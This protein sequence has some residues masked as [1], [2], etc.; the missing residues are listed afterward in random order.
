MM[1]VSNM[2]SAT[3]LPVDFHSAE[4][5]MSTSEGEAVAKASRQ[6]E[7]MLVR[8]ILNTAR[9]GAS[10]IA[11][12][13]ST[14]SEIYRDLLTNHMADQISQSGE[15]GFAKQLERELSRQTS[16]GKKSEPMPTTANVSGRAAT[17]GY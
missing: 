11:E 16:V 1:S 9:V 7:A 10:G 8:Q 6:F 13:P 14:T 15:L 5:K 12:G 3:V 4:P 17:G 2:P